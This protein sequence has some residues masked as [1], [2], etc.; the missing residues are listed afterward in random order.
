MLAFLN[1]ISWVR[2]LSYLRVFQKT[3]VFIAL[4]VQVMIDMIPFMIVLIGALLG[5]TFSYRALTRYSFNASIKHNYRVMFGDFDTDDYTNAEWFFFI[6]SSCLM[7][8]IMLNMLIAIMS[9]TYAKVMGSI[10]PSDYQELNN[11]ILEMEEILIWN[12]NEGEAKFLHFA[13]YLEKREEAEWEGQVQAL[14]KK[15]D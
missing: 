6:F 8:L 5:F 12:R 2:A 4:L 15:L 9:D 10:V 3:R 13:H 7:T 1:L 11:M 14:M